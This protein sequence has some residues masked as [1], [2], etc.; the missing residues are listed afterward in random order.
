MLKVEHLSEGE[1]M[2]N[3]GRVLAVVLSFLSLAWVLVMLIIAWVQKI[4]TTGYWH[5]P[6]KP[7]PL[8]PIRRSREPVNDDDE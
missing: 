8:K 3:G 5:R 2:T 1:K 4:D 7:E 6:V